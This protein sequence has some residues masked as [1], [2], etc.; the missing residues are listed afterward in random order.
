MWKGR[1]MHVAT[2]IC[3]HDVMFVQIIYKISP[4][5]VVYQLVLKCTYIA[6]FNFE[7]Q[8]PRCVLNHEVQSEREAV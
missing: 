8:H 4:F 3:F 6:I 2:P 1:Q 5:F 7:V